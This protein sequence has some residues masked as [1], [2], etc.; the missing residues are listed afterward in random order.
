VQ[1]NQPE[2]PAAPRVLYM[3]FL[4]LRL[5]PGPAYEAYVFAS[6]QR[7]LERYEGRERIVT[8]H[9][10]AVLKQTERMKAETR[11]TLVGERRRV[12]LE[13]VFGSRLN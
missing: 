9:F 6:V 3:P 11:A 13:H 10:A 12:V 2:P 1:S 8:S 7:A 5:H 4:A